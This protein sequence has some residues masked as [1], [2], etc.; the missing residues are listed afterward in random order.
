MKDANLIDK[1]TYFFNRKM[2]VVLLINDSEI[3]LFIP[4]K[5]GRGNK[6]VISISV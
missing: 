5:R 2:Y 4:G 6:I 3:Y 1:H